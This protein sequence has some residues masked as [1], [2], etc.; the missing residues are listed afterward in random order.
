MAEETTTAPDLFHWRGFLKI[1]ASGVRTS[2]AAVLPLIVGQIVG[3]PAIGLF[4]GLSGLYLSVSDKEG[5]TVFT[6]CCALI[7]NAATMFAGTI[8]GND[9]WLSISLLFLV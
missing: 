4:I 1:E 2:A 8:V 7:L 9:V 5:S 6:L 3:F